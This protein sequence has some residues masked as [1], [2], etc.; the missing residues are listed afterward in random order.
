[1]IMVI[2]TIGRNRPDSIL[3]FRRDGITKNLG[4]SGAGKPLKDELAAGGER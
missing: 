4:N 1:M 3:N 2:T